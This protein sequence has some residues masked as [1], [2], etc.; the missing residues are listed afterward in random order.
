MKYENVQMEKETPK[1]F[2]LLGRTILKSGKV[3]EQEI[4]IFSYKPS[5]AT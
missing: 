4:A 3:A 2:S 5:T 1:G